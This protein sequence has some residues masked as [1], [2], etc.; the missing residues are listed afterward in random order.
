MLK[1]ILVPLVLP[2][3]FILNHVSDNPLNRSKQISHGSAKSVASV[4]QSINGPADTEITVKPH[5]LQG[6]TG[7]LEKMAVTD[8]SATLEVD[9]NRL[10]GY[11]SKSQFSSLRFG[12]APDS[13]FTILVFNRVLRGPL[14]GSLALIPQSSA[15]LPPILSASF[16]QLV[17]D[18]TEPG[19]PYELVVRDGRTGFKFFN[20]EGNVYDYNAK[21]RSFKLEDG[22][23]LISEEFAVN[24]DRK[25][26]R[27]VASRK[28]LRNGDDAY[29]RD[30]RIG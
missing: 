5:A 19:E 1:T 16:N 11:G 9:L 21:T 22:R 23:L 7:T 6:Q 28:N 30:H 4:K 24:L 18:K 12:V 8:G 14:S 27:R 20:I 15:N 25:G 29:N 2:V 3:L 13:F 17:I 10:N 26:R